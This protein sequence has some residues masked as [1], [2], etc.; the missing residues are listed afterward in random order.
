METCETKPLGE[1]DLSHAGT[2]YLEALHGIAHEFWELVYRLTQLY[3][4]VRSSLVQ[5]LHPSGNRGRK[6]LEVC[7]NDQPRAARSSRIAIRSVGG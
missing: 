7:S 4:R 5:T 3:Q 2:Q 6:V 1:L